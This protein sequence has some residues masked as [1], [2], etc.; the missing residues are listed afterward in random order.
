MV[1]RL[2]E[3]DCD[4]IEA[5]RGGKGYAECFPYKAMYGMN[6]NI[7]TFNMMTL[8]ADS[9]IGFHKHETDMEGYL[10]LDGTAKYN[11][12]GKEKSLEAGD[13]AICKKG[14]SHSLE[15]TGGEAVTFLAFILE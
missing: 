9:A 15:A 5:P 3:M 11:D 13:L 14:D 10:I 6:V 7:K 8:A 1:I 2:E 12:N 4:K